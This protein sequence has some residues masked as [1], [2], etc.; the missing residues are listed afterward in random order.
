L[1]PTFASWAG[2]RKTRF[3]ACCVCATLWNYARIKCVLCGATSGIGYQEIE[4]A[5]DAIKA[6]TCNSCRAYV[7]IL[8]QY[9]DPSLDRIADDVASLGLDML[10]SA[11]G[12]RRGGFNPFIH[13]Y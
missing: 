5:N 8:H 13:G 6:E 9:K 4:N 12:Y 10:M 11:A 3:C 1:D 2:A 7:K